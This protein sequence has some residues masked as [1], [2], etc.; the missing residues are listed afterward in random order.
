VSVTRAETRDEIKCSRGN[1][2]FNEKHFQ[3]QFQRV[4]HS[5]ALVYFAIFHRYVYSTYHL[6]ALCSLL[7]L[8]TVAIPNDAIIICF[9]SKNP[10]LLL[11]LP[12]PLLSLCH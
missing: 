7:S 9:V 4:S 2:I 5:R 11:L 6:S 3:Y 12:A 1:A 10:I 8:L